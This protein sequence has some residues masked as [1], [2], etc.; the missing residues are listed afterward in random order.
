VSR[1]R[2]KST[3]WRTLCALGL[4]AT[5]CTAAGEARA[6]AAA[7]DAATPPAAAAATPPAPATPAPPAPAPPRPATAPS[8]LA[9]W[10][11]PATA[12]FIPIPAIDTEPHSGLTLGLIPTWLKTGEHDEI[13]QIVAPDIIHSQYF[14]WGVHM[15]VFGFP[16]ADTQWSV[17]GGLKERVE[18]EFDGRYLTGQTRSGAVSWSVEAIYDRSGTQRF[19]G[20]GNL[21]QRRGETA[22]I[23][24]QAVLDALFGHNFSPR[25]QLAYE[26]RVRYVE[27]LPES[28]RGLPPIG[29]LYPTLRGLGGEHQLQHT[30]LLTYDTRDSPIIPHSGARY[31][32]Y[33]GFVSRALGSSV[34][35]TYFGAEARRYFPL[36]RDATLAWHV[37]ARYMPSAADAPFWALSSLGGDR[38][39]TNEREPLRGNGFDRY[40]DRNLFAT[41]AELRVRVAGFNAF[42]T[43]VSLEL[44]PFIDAGKVFA[45][46]GGSP[47]S[48]LHLAGGLG[49]R[50]VAS[51]FVV[52][53]VDIGFAH[54]KPAVFSG[55]DYPF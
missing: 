2:R 32:V 30:A 43:R 37:G 11:D 6:T 31:I 22:Y 25:L 49:F 4:L 51:P 13:E 38:S 7:A 10:L 27:V 45:T 29:T 52:G 35:Y 3:G 16:S 24:N 1:S 14:G 39:V 12:P 44:A 33:D 54:S 19:F 15:R 53:Y 50:G 8:G 26:P 9:R 18:R 5:E 41:G 34:S 36:G 46:M 55:L 20:L 23:N 17:V 40:I 48:R 42:R 21:S 47:F 28:I